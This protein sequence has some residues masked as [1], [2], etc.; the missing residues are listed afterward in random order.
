MYY[1]YILKSS[2]LGILYTGYTSDLRKRLQEHNS[3]K[4][5]STKPYIPW[6]LVFYA[7][8]ETERLAKG[9]ELYLK[10]GSG[11]AFANKRL[12][13]KAL[14]KDASI[15]ADKVSETLV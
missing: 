6:K 10:S 13:K 14:A 12:L 9:F 15:V 5:F 3:G 4:S 1:T 7:S 2:K 11:K 8:F